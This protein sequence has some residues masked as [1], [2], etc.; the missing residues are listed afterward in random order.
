[1]QER[2]DDQEIKPIVEG[3]GASTFPLSLEEKEWYVKIILRHL[4]VDS[5][6][7]L[8]EDFKGGLQTLGVL[9]AI[10]NHPERFRDVFTKENLKPLD[11]ATVDALFSIELAEVGS[12]A[13]AKQELAI[14]NWRDYLQDCESKLQNYT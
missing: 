2:L 7:Y 10:K 6:T 1:M 11:A 13:R 9:E 8:L 3:Q 4:L 14:I 5:T 12:N